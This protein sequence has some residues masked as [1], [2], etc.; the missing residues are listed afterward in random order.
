MRA[1][2][3]FHADQ[4]WLH[5]GKKFQHLVSIELFSQYRLTMMIDTVNLKNIF[6]QIDANSSNVHDGCPFR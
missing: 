6:C 2:T 1:T 3:S 5:F 4:T